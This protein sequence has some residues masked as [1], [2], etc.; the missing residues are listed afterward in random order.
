MLNPRIV[1]G[2]AVVAAA[3]IYATPTVDA[4]ANSVGCQQ[5]ACCYNPCVNYKYR[6]GC[7]CCKTCDPP[8]KQVLT[9]L[10]P[11][12]CGCAVAVPVCV[13]ACC[14][15][16]P[17]VSSRCGLF[18]G[19]VSYEWSCGYRIDVAIGKRSG[20]VTVTYFGL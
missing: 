3:M 10:D 8:V 14:T 12:N 9:V 4:A 17:C 19:H 7:V 13:P 18:R 1:L 15:G 20:N 2:A 11:C 6:R 16:A 5:V